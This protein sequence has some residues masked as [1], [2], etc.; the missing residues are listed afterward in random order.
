M[1]V[2]PA[3]HPFQPDGPVQK[4]YANFIPPVRD[5]ELGLCSLEDPAKNIHRN[6]KQLINVVLSPLLFLKGHPSRDCLQEVVNGQQ[7]HHYFPLFFYSLTYAFSI[8][9]AMDLLKVLSNWKNLRF[10]G[11][12]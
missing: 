2:V 5:C 4:P 7:R 3:R 12:S 1:L 10:A 9:S 11:L 6:K 8:S